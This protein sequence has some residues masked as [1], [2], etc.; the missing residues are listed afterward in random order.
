MIHINKKNDIRIEMRIS[1]LYVDIPYEKLFFK[2]STTFFQEKDMIF[3]KKCAIIS[4][5]KNKKKNTFE[6]NKKYEPFTVMG[7]I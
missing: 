3:D 4:C 7:Y 5:G 1:F 6:R 2:T